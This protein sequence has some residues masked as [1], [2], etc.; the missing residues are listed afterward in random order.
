MKNNEDTIILATF[1]PLY[2]Y[3]N[4]AIS[5]DISNYMGKIMKAKYVD[6]RVSFNS[7]TDFVKVGY[8]S[9][10]TNQNVTQTILYIK[11]G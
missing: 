8:S 2:K 1:C 5:E 3:S 6:Y 11:R 9:K 7:K 10:Y 4:L